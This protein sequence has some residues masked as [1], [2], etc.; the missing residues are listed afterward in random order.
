MKFC[1]NQASR[2]VV[3][4]CKEKKIT[5]DKI[6]NEKARTKVAEITG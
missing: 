1:Q 6:Y 3:N 5:G 4:L 2:N